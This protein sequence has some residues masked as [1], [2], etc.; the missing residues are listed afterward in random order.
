MASL[1]TTDFEEAK[2]L[3]TTWFVAEHTMKQ[4]E[5]KG[6]PLGDILIRYHEKH[7]QHIRS[8]SQSKVSVE[9]WSDF[10]KASTVQD[11]ANMDK[12]EEFQR[13]L[14]AKGLNP[15]AVQRV[16]SV[17]KAAI[18][19]A[20]KRG[21]IVSAPKVLS[22]K[23]PQAEPRG[24]PL[25]TAEIKALFMA[26]AP[27][28]RMFIMWALGTAARPEAVLTLHG[29]QIDTDNGLVNLNPTGRAQNKKY[30]PVVRLIPA[31][32]DHVPDGFLV[33]NGQEAV[34]SI[35]TAWNAAVVRA[36][37]DGRVH[38]YSLRHTAARWMR[39]KGVTMDDVALQLGHKRLGVTETYTA[40]SPDYLKAA[41]DALE[42]LVRTS[43][44]PDGKPLADVDWLVR[45]SAA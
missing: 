18:N 10:W 33:G 24:R 31:L 30:R 44:A 40:F 16:L 21:E 34:G 13:W 28:V 12:Q 1:G 14:G 39:S 41:A 8:A 6:V 22:I 3:L 25:S 2:R 37:L 27:H 19:R 5:P 4:E 20:Y 15:A 7:G 17:G 42:L 45:R 38:A 9:Y 43:C 23:V 26:A 32:C 35:K 36:G 11:V 29:K